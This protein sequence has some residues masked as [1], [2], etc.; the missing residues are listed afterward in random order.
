MVSKTYKNKTVTRYL[1][2]GG[3]GTESVY[4]TTLTEASNEA[5]RIVDKWGSAR[6]FRRSNDDQIIWESVHVDGV[7]RYRWCASWGVENTAEG[8]ANSVDEAFERAHEA[9]SGKGLFGVVDTRLGVVLV[10]AGC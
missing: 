10:N 7:N 3:L 8:F 4:T 5:L 2:C 6:V 9:Y 1:V